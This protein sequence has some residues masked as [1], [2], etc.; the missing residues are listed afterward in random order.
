[1]MQNGLNPR[2]LELFR[3]VADLVAGYPDLKTN[4]GLWRL[5]TPFTVGADEGLCER[6]DIG[7]RRSTVQPIKLSMVPTG[8]LPTRWSFDEDGNVKVASWRCEIEKQVENTTL[9]FGPPYR[10][11]TPFGPDE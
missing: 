1:M 9:I 4:F 8:A 6:I 3:S 5:G 10:A 7:T 2:E 11:V